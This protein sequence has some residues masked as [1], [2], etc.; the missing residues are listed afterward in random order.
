M[1]LVV[2]GEQSRNVHHLAQRDDGIEVEQRRHGRRGERRPGVLERGRR[3]AGRDGEPGL[4]R[5]VRRVLDDGANPRL[6]QHV[7]DFV[8]VVDDAGHA[9]GQDRVAVL[10]QRHHA[11][12]DVH[13]GVDESGGDVAGVEGALGWT[14]RQRDDFAVVD[15]DGAVLERSRVD[16]HQRA[17]DERVD[18]FGHR[19]RS[20]GR[21]AAAASTRVSRRR[22]VSGCRRRSKVVRLGDGPGMFSRPTQGIRVTPPGTALTTSRCGASPPRFLASNRR[23]RPARRPSRPPPRTTTGIGSLRRHCRTRSGRRR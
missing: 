22:I 23:R 7:R 5:R 10:R 16:V 15:G 2:T 11:R 8:W 20:P 4:Q 14:L 3:H 19:Y 17:A 13:V 1:D 12:L 6:S 21:V 18:P 9:T